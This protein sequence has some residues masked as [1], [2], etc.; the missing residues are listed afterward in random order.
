MIV[1]AGMI[2][3]GKTTYAEKLAEE[4]NVQLFKEPVDDNPFLPLYYMNPKKWAFSL[5][6]FFL[7]KRF[8]QVKESSKL[9]NAV[10][11]R[12]IYEDEIFTR[13]N[14]DTGNISKEEYDLYVDLLDNMMEEVNDLQKKA[15]DLLVYL[16]APKEYILN[17]I[18]NRGREF[19]QPTES[20]QLLE[21]YS[22]LLDMYEQWYTNYDKSRKMR[23]DVSNYDIINNPADWQEV[24]NLITQRQKCEYDL[25]G[26]KFQL[27]YEDKLKD[28]DVDLGTFDTPEECIQSVNQ[29]WE[30]NNFKPTYMRMWYTNNSLVIDYGNHLGFYVIKGINDER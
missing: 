28:V 21:Y 7:N 2:G 18:V 5:Q 15:P 4:L 3:V 27:V 29:W 10:L 30:D 8:K 26:N 17:K 24:Y 23:I 25:V 14:Y 19:E 16:T 1:I 12:S 9:K 13:L 11:D 20:N 22:S 6:L